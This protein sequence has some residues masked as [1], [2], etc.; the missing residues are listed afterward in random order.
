[1]QFPPMTLTWY[2]GFCVPDSGNVQAIEKA[3]A[4][5]TI[6]IL[7]KDA[8]YPSHLL[9]PETKHETE[10]PNDTQRIVRIVL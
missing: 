6:W 8:H 4:Y 7:H 10:Q 3:H 5:Q 9:S 2:G 1:M